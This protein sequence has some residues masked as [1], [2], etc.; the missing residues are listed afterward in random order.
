[1]RTACHLFLSSLLGAVTVGCADIPLRTSTWVTG[2]LEVD[3]G[4][5][6]AYECR[7]GAR[8]GLEGVELADAN[9]RRIR[10]SIGPQAGNSYPAP[11]IQGAAAVAVLEPGESRADQIY[12][13]GLLTVGNQMSKIA[14]Q[15]DVKGTADLS[16]SSPQHSIKGH[17]EFSDC[18]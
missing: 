4:P 12:P 7:T 3:G 11:S 2:D 17:V 6:R 1:M 15:R 18:H 8:Y 9:G 10:A 13:C 14:G 5:F 16:C